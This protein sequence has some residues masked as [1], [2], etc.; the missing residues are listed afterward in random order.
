MPYTDSSMT[1]G[2]WWGPIDGCVS[3]ERLPQV[4]LQSS[5]MSLSTMLCSPGYCSDHPKVTA[6]QI[7]H[8]ATFTSFFGW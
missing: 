7:K 3:L 4:A 1:I 8:N 6:A 2:I 5:R